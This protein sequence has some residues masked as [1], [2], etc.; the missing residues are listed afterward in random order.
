M[1][2]LTIRN[3]QKDSPLLPCFLIVAAVPL[4]YAE[5]PFSASFVSD[6][7]ERF[8]T[9]KVGFAVLKGTERHIVKKDE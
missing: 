4:M 8:A 6:R 1:S 9:W 2:W 3:S 7:K 5:E